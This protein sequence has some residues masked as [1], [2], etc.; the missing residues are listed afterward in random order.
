MESNN[1]LGNSSFWKR[2]AKETFILPRSTAGKNI[3][4]EIYTFFPFLNTSSMTK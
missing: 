1:I 3:R 2:K 4:F